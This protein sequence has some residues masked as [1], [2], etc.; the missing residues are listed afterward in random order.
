[1]IEILARFLPRLYEDYPRA[2]V[3]ILIHHKPFV[4]SMKRLVAIQNG[5]Q[6][7]KA[8]ARLAS[9]VSFNLA[10]HLLPVILS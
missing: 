4:H 1:M 6:L 2:K 3:S 7:L 10:A 5:R 8:T 9:L